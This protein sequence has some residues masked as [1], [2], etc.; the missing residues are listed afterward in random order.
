[1]T[2]QSLTDRS[3]MLFGKYQGY[4]LKNIP[5]RY[6]L[7]IYAN[8]KLRDDLKQYIEKRREQYE[9]EV[10]EANRQMRR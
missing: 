4:E 5:G 1:M 10:K 2:G 9:Q 3:L 6:M 8:L 7:W